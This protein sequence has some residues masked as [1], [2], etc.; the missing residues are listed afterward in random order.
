[1][2]GSLVASILSLNSIGCI[3]LPNER[4]FHSFAHWFFGIYFSLFTP[5]YLSGILHILPGL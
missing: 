4:K 2:T 1:L 3:F 5:C